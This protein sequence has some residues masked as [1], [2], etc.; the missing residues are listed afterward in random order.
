[1]CANPVVEKHRAIFKEKDS[2]RQRKLATVSLSPP[3]RL[4]CWFSSLRCSILEPLV[5]PQLPG[6][7]SRDSADTLLDLICPK[8]SVCQRRRVAEH[9]P[10]LEIHTL[11]PT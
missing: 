10:S 11:P 5:L 4:S 7:H 1:M 8:W 2:G 6:D 9:G 3:P